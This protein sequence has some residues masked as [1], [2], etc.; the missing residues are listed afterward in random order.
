MG[1]HGC[2]PAAAT[3][4]HAKRYKQRNG[5]EELNKKHKM[6]FVGGSSVPRGANTCTKDEED[7]SSADHFCS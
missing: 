2:W 1:N 6:R 7:V 4:T 5:A 3:S